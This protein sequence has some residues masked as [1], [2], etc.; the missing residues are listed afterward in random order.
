VSFRSLLP[1]YKPPPSL[2]MQWRAVFDSLV[3]PLRLFH[4]CLR[5]PSVLWLADK[6]P[7]RSYTTLADADRGAARALDQIDGTPPRTWTVGYEIRLFVGPVLEYLFEFTSVPQARRQEM[8]GPLRKQLYERLKPCFTRP[9]LLALR[10]AVSSEK[11]FVLPPDARQE[12]P[13]AEQTVANGGTQPGQV[14]NEP[15]DADGE[16]FTLR[17]RSILEMMLG[18]EI[19]SERRRQTRAVS[20]DTSIARTTPRL[21]VGTSLPW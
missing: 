4:F 3:A 11:G 15:G 7:Q 2:S 1:L 19:T 6:Q 17:Q 10:H 18:H 13:G 21:T 12:L 8:F 14:G 9:L 16:E 20:L 5:N